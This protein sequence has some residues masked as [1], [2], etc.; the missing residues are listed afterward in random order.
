[1]LPAKQPV[2]AFLP[3]RSYGFRFI[4]QGWSEL[5]SISFVNFRQYIH[6]KEKHIK[7]KSSSK[8]IS[9]GSSAST[10]WIWVSVRV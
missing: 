10:S 8:W 4:V 7:E 5:I 2:F 3:L 6:I 9:T 1:V